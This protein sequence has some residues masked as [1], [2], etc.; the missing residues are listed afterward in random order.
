MLSQTLGLEGIVW[1]ITTVIGFHSAKQRSYKEK[2]KKNA[3]V[4]S[5]GCILLPDT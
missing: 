5:K 3:I 2:L 4:S 1:I